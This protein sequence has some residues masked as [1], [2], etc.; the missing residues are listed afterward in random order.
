MPRLTNRGP[1]MSTLST[2]IGLISGLNTA[3]LVDALINAQRA[4]VRRLESRAAG[5]EATQ[6]GLKTLEANIFSIK[7]AVQQLGESSRFQAYNVQNSQPEQLAVTAGTTATPGTYHFQAIRGAATH[8]VHSRGFANADQQSIGTGTL[9]V[10]NGGFLSRPTLVDALNGGAGV[11]RGAIRITDRTGASADIDLS[12]VHTVEDVLNAINADETI[13]VTATTADG[14]LVLTDTSGGAG[15]LTVADLN[16]GQTAVDL[17]IS[18]SAAGN[19]LTGQSVFSVTSDFTF[20]LLNDGNGLRTVATAPALRITLSDDTALEIAVHDAATIG[21]V[22]ER[23][24]THED[25]G[26]KVAAALVDGRLELTDLSGGGGAGNFTVENINDAS[27]LRELGL[28]VTAAGGTITGR[29]LSAG[30]NSVLLRNL[31]SG[32]GIDQT[33]QIT[34]TDR[35]GTTATVDLTNAESLDEVLAAI[36][37]ATSGGGTKLQ[38]TAEINPRGNGITVRDTSGATASNLVIADVGGSTLA[39]QLGIAVDDAVEAIDS[40][41]LALRYVNAATS[42]SEYAPDGGGIEPGSIRITDSAGNTAT[43]DISNAVENIGDVLQRINAVAGVSVRAELNETGDGFVLVDEAGGAGTLQVAEVGGTTAADLRLLGEAVVG[44]DGAQRIISRRAAIVDIEA[45]DTLEDVVE[46]I[47]ASA[48][49]ATASVLDTGA[50]INP[51]RLRIVSSDSGAAGRL[52]VDS[53]DLD[54]GLSTVTAGQDALLRV[55]PNAATGVLRA[56]AT[57]AFDDAVTGLDVDV[58]AAGSTPATVT[59]T[60]NALRIEESLQSFVNAYNTFVGAAAELTKFDPETSQRGVLQG[61]TTV[62]RL[63]DR[64]DRLVTGSSPDDGAIGSLAALGVRVTTGGRLTFDKEQFNEQYAADPAGV[65]DF[66][67][68]EETGFADRAFE[69]LEALTDPATGS[70]AIQQNSLQSSI[71][72]LDTRIE[73]LDEILEVRRAR[74]FEEFLRM[75]QTLAA[76]TAQQESLLGIQPLRVN[77]APRGV[78]G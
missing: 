26:G 7:S 18:G 78:S 36:H 20:N 47:N 29:R 35:A 51:A 37:G 23:I 4:T 62:L 19:V 27:V 14:Q 9:V 12:A 76:L 61:D 53:G 50:A 71:D 3:E 5:F 73:Q 55:G 25:N 63:R 43:V 64:L 40:G 38:L 57:N 13:G 46:R 56:S 32:A 48:G 44:G 8:E 31:R 69:A 28:D 65:S 11:R 52:L 22:L 10:S 24:N 2:G 77:A 67:L 70:L 16:G 49:F 59:V 41:S 30:L 33:G 39:A 68:T 6:T 17:G 54:L 21:D 1:D 60:R 74:L 72:A 66:F 15:T 58:L 34:L 45:G 42:V 75:E